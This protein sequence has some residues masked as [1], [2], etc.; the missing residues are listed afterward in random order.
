MNGLINR[1]ELSFI[2]IG[3][4]GAARPLRPLIMFETIY[5]KEKR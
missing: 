5:G 4:V 3:P 1:E 2:L